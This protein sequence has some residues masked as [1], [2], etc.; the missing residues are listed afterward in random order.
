MMFAKVGV[1]AEFETVER[2][3]KL[4]QLPEHWFLTAA[5]TFF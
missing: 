5:M 3:I 4:K 2:F 1:G